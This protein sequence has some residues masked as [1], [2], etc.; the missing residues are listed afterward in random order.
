M[1]GK[2]EYWENKNDIL[3]EV[4][5]KQGTRDYPF[6]KKKQDRKFYIKLD[7]CKSK[8]SIK[9]LYTHKNQ[10]MLLELVLNNV[11]LKKRFNYEINGFIDF[12]ESIRQKRFNKDERKNE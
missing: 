10:K 4:I 5:S 8:E 3:F 7:N 11:I 9:W 2:V 6:D 12:M 1:S